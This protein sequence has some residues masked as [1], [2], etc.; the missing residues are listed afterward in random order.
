MVVTCQAEEQEKLTQ[1]LHISVDMLTSQK[2]FLLSVMVLLFHEC[3]GCEGWC[4]L[5][6]GVDTSHPLVQVS[7]CA[8]VLGHHWH[9]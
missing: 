2:L 7:L 3:V 8:S 1:V 9:C 4:A 6:G 5:F